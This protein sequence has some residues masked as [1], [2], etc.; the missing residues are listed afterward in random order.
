[1]TETPQTADLL[2]ATLPRGEKSSLDRLFGALLPFSGLLLMITFVVCVSLL[3][4]MNPLNILRRYNLLTVL[5][6][7]TVVAIA[8]LG[9]T[10]VIISGGIDLSVGSVMA[11]TTVTIALGLEKMRA[12]PWAAGL[13]GIATGGLCGCLNGLMITKLRIVP[14]VATL[15]MWTVARGTAKF[16]AAEQTVHVPTTWLNDLMIVSLK[17]PGLWILLVSVVAMLLVLR[18]TTF[19]RY[20]IA[21]GSAESTARLCGVRVDRMKVGIYTLSGLL[22]GL[23]GLLLFSRLSV[24]DPTV[25]VGS[26]LY[27]IAAV[28][29]GGGSLS[30]GEG[31]IAGTLVGALTM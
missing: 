23:A 18:Y 15:G 21:I 22:T 29:I 13:L 6:Q 28:V 12:W 20:T 30:G 9:M 4:N 19:G 3:M 8:A 14:F 2:E 11:L 27:V 7:T 31:S 24:G 25:A 5:I 17:S 1:M 16:L 26:E 10:F